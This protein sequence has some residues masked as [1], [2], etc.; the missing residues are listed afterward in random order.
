MEF[1]Q[2]IKQRESV[3]SYDP[4][5]KVSIETVHRILDAGRIAPSAHNR[6]PWT[7]VVV[8]SEE[9]LKKVRPCYH[10]EWFQNAPQILV[11]VGDKSKAW[12]RQKDGINS[13]ETDL[14]IAMDH[15]VL[16]AENEGVGTCWILAYDYEIL[17]KA[18][19]L[20]E[21]E[22]IFSITPLGY[23][24]EGYHKRNNKIRKSLEEVVRYI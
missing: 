8:S 14:A 12:V 7:F 23:P 17:A 9:M 18:I 22:T 16:A 24:E 15:I 2:L 11:I 20:K 3:R 5:K 13:I 4:Q 6:Q 10:R 19:G 1:Y 21:N